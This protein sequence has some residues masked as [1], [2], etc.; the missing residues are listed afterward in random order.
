VCH[1]LYANTVERLSFEEMLGESTDENDVV[2]PAV[3][4][5]MVKHNISVT[6]TA[7][8]RILTD[9]ELAW[10]RTF[11]AVRDLYLPVLR[12]IDRF[13]SIEL[14]K[15]VVRAFPSAE[16]IFVRDSLWREQQWPKSFPWPAPFIR[17]LDDV[18]DRFYDETR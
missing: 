5:L 17:A 16:R 7:R 14:L 13:Y 9:S 10:S 15:H 12:P 1:T 8:I 4:A 2:W 3:R 11:P 6:G 18:F